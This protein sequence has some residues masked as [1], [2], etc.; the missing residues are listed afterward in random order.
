MK[1]KGISPIEQ[2]VE[3]IVVAVF[4]AALLGLLAWQFIGPR[5]KV[6]LGTDTV[7]IDQATDVV[8]RKAEEVQRK[9]AS[10]D[11]AL[12]TDVPSVAV[13]EQ[14]RARF[15]GPVAPKKELVVALGGPI[16]AIG[17][18]GELPTVGALTLTA[19]QVPAVSAPIA[20]QYAATID[21]REVQSYPELAA[22]LPTEIPFDKA[23]VTVEGTFNGAELGRVLATDPDGEAGSMA[24]MPKYW[25]DGGVQI[26]RVDLH[27]EELQPDGSWSNATVVQPIPGQA[28]LQL[29]GTAPGAEITLMDLQTRVRE[30]GEDADD[31][32]RPDFYTTVMGQVWVAPS[33]VKTDGSNQD[34]QLKDRKLR[35]RDDAESDIADLE[36]RVADIPN[37]PKNKAQRAGFTRRI[38]ARKVELRKINDELRTMGV[39]S[40]DDTTNQAPVDPEGDASKAKP[41]LEDDAVRIWAHDITAQRGKT[42]RY[43]L[44]VTLSN[45]VYGRDAALA[46]DQADLAKSPTLVSSDSPWSENIAVLDSTKYFI[47]NAQEN[48]AFGAGPS[49]TA[50]VYVF[51]W[52]YYRKGTIS[53]QPGDP[54]AGEVRV[55]EMEKLIAV[56]PQ[57]PGDE[58]LPPAENV[59]PP[60]GRGRPDRANEP[61]PPEN[62]DPGNPNAPKL[63][64]RPTYKEILFE[65]DAFLLDVAAAPSQ[66][67]GGAAQGS[68]GYQAFMRDTEGAI[69][70]KSPLAERSQAD[71]AWVAQSYAIG[72]QELRPRAEKQ[73]R[74]PKERDEADR[75]PPGKSGGGR[76]GGSGGGGG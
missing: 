52:G 6:T 58:P 21:Q 55:P 26:L 17:P 74:K 5:N 69:T 15:R 23:W 60:G 24:A 32:R 44:G 25:W 28:K 67:N 76:G 27:R 75:P 57:D 37:E 4:A 10:R 36:K 30:A 68:A 51:Y 13:G 65:R 3:K 50:E 39:E 18:G 41:L 1:L 9:V 46:A 61:P 29:S 35:E 71:Y 59:P 22:L 64:A 7:T 56:L 2:H 14:F 40:A 43:R 33:E 47:V 62:V 66:A 34:Q 54:L 73:K 72:E 11:P 16:R 63:P 49:A 20:A 45:P 19:L 53:M 48:D 8:A 12:P 38:E 70:I 31:I 42:Y